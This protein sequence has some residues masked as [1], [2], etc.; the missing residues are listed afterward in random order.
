MSTSPLSAE[1]RDIVT[2][3]REF[4]D[5]Q[6]KPVVRGSSSTRTPIPRP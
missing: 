5:D 4:V 6:V 2:L 1:E 3:V